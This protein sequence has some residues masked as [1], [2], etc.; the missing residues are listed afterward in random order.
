MPIP[1]E[2]AHRMLYHFTH[3]DNLPSLIERGLLSTNH[4]AFPASHCHSIAAST[5][6]HRRATMT[7]PCGAQGV[8]HDY[9]PL[10]FGALSLMLPGVVNKKNV[11]QPDIIYLEFP[12]ELLN[13]SGAVFT[14]AA[15]N[16]HIPPN[17]F[18][19]PAYLDRLNWREID[20]IK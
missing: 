19:E 9:V 17:F 5:I 1:A 3:I 8:V 6:Q 11:D 20:S 15:A 4:P 14:D 2:H 18:A 16:T 7:V 10:Y 12:I 13:R